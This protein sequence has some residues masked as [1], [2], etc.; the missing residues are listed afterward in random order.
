MFATIHS[1]IDAFKD[2]NFL[3]FNRQQQQ[4]PPPPPPALAAVDL[5]VFSAN[6]R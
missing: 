4:Q 2:F 3:R 6:A 5:L 1:N